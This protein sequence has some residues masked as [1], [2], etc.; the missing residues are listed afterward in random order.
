MAVGAAIEEEEEEEDELSYHR[1]SHMQL[2]Q[3][4]SSSPCDASPSFVFTWRN[5]FL[6]LTGISIHRELLLLL[7][8]SHLAHTRFLLLSTI[9]THTRARA[10]LSVV[11]NKRTLNQITTA[12][13]CTRVVNRGKKGNSRIHNGDG[14]LQVFSRLAEIEETL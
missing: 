8:L 9:H 5:C 12:R 2:Y 13:M 4:R 3:Q 11:N 6:H 10:R 14:T 7:F 1:G